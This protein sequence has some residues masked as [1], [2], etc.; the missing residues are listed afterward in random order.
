MQLLQS[1]ELSKSPATVLPEGAY[2]P[3]PPL[4]GSG[5]TPKYQGWCLQVGAGRDSLVVQFSYCLWQ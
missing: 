1:R 2:S 5:A 4:M 3:H